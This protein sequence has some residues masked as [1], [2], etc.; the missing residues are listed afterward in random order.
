MLD[1][2]RFIMLY[3]CFCIERIF[4]FAIRRILKIVLYD[5]IPRLVSWSILFIFLDLKALVP[6]LATFAANYAISAVYS[7]K[8]Y[9]TSHLVWLSCF[10]GVVFP[11]CYSREKGN[12]NDRKLFIL[13]N[14]N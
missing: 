4:T 10:L 1:F 14:F 6:L 8:K 12:Y 2:I 3:V 5:K 13:Q 7:T 11:C 9:K